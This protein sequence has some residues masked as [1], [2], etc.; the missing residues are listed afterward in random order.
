MTIKL[1]SWHPR[2]HEAEIGSA[3]IHMTFDLGVPRP[4][5]KRS[6]VCRRGTNVLLRRPTSPPRHPLL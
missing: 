5:M 6:P 2:K 3:H 1:M 4:H